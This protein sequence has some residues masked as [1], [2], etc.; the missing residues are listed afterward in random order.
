VTLWQSGKFDEAA[1]EL[2][3]VIRLK[4]DYAEAYYTL[5]TVYKQAGDLPKAA[6]ALRKAI[7]LQPDFAGAHTTLASVLNQQGDAQA[8]AAER[9]LGAELTQEKMTRQSATF[10]TSSGTKLMNAGDLDGAILQFESAIKADSAYA[11]AHQ[12]LSMALERK[13]D[14]DRAGKELEIFRRLQAKGPS[15]Q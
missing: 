5:G 1:R 10:A 6:S 13:G 9:K 15:V 3:E 11:P 2:N 14:K 12:Q 4:P 8:A 7:E